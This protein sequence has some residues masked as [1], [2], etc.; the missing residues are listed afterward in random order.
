MHNKNKIYLDTSAYLKAHLDERGSDNVN[1]I[2]DLTTQGSRT[3]IYMSYWVIA[4][5][6][7]V[8]DRQRHT[9][10]SRRDVLI[11][12][13]LKLVVD[14]KPNINVVSV[15][16][17]LIKQTIEYISKYH[18][19]ADDALRLCTANKFRCNYFIAADSHFMNLR[20]SNL[21]VINVQDN[22][23]IN[24]PLNNLE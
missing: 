7:A 21:H 17:N 18:V 16:Q 6:I 13:I 22:M 3:K 8:I 12:T 10:K 5:A 19:S 23:A 1:S 14:A 4:E 15:N 20:L 11:S 24:N 2:L 9:Y